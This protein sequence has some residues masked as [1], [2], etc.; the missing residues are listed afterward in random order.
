MQ[1]ADTL[2]TIAEV[3]VALAGFT[4]VVAVLGRRSSGGWSAE[5]LLQLRAL[6]E[7]SLT[8]FFVSFVPAILSS[9][10]DSEAAVW[11]WSNGVLAVAHLA[12]LASFF[13]RTTRGAAPTVGQRISGVFGAAFVLLHLTAAVGI[14]AWAAPLVVLGLLGLLFVAA[15]NFVLLLF[16][17]HRA[18]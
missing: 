9:V 11:R 6:V 1:Y 17:V 4:G 10:V 14:L 12:N 3:A 16:R 8:V 18:V 5:E 13:L 15:Q 2:S 7:T